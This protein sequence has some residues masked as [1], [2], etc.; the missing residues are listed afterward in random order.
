MTDY[1]MDRAVEHEREAPVK[2]KTAAELTRQ[3]SHARGPQ[4]SQTPKQPT[5]QLAQA[6]QRNVGPSR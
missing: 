2:E 6:L 5:E 1:L 4:I 3:Y